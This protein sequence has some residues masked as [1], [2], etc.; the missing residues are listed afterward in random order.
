ML[1]G[2]QNHRPR[3]L[4]IRNMNQEHTGLRLAW[5]RRCPARDV[6]FHRFSMREP[7]GEP[8]SVFD[9]RH[10]WICVLRSRRRDQHPFIAVR[11]LRK[12]LG[13]L[14]SKSSQ[15]IAKGRP[16]IF[17]TGP[18]Q[19]AV[20]SPACDLREISHLQ[21]SSRGIPGSCLSAS[22]ARGG[23]RSLRPAAC[24]RGNSAAGTSGSTRSRPAGALR[25]ECW[26][27]SRR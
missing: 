9:P 16:R 3:R 11:R 23:M 19:T 6:D 20:G 7:V 25:V 27:D 4:L 15:E 13:I 5:C 2:Q 17:E 22:A 10:Q 1:R 26:S 18:R 24:R 14:S 21:P 8:A 12:P